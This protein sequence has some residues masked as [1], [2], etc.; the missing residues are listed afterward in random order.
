MWFHFHY[1]WIKWNF[2]FVIVQPETKVNLCKTRVRHRYKQ[3]PKDGWTRYKQFPKNRW[4]PLAWLMALALCIFIYVGSPFKLIHDAETYFQALAL[5]SRF[6]TSPSWRLC[7]H[8]GQWFQRVGIA[9]DSSRHS[10]LFWRQKNEML[11]P[12]WN[13]LHSKLSSLYLV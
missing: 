6:T 3:F 10:L 7:Y 11:Q 13:H 4:V 5:E 1:C 8:H 12:S 9:N 2:F